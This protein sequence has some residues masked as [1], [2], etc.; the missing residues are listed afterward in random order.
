MKFQSKY[1]VILSRAMLPPCEG[2]VLLWKQRILS[3]GSYN[4]SLQWAH[5]PT[6]FCVSLS[7]ANAHLKQLGG[8]PPGSNPEVAEKSLWSRVSVTGSNP[9][10]MSESLLRLV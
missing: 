2:G 6:E 8:A 10:V 7:S 5:T 9:V 1:W 4:L 3:K